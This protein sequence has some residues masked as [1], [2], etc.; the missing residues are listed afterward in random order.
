MLAN[1]YNN[2]SKNPIECRNECFARTECSFFTFYYE[3][4]VCLL[5][6]AE[7]S[8]QLGEAKTHTLKLIEPENLSVSGSKSCSGMYSSIFAH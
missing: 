7:Q 8:P 1:A 3:P 5:W 6:T 4:K 2:G